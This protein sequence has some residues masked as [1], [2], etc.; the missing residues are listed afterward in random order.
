M[1]RVS[2]N[3]RALPISV[4]L[5]IVAL[6]AVFALYILTYDKDAYKE[7]VAGRRFGF[8][9]GRIFVAQ[10]SESR[11][12]LLTKMR[13]DR[14][15]GSDAGGWY[16][17]YNQD[18]FLLWQFMGVQEEKV[19]I[20]PPWGW[21]SPWRSD[22]AY[23]P[24]PTQC[25]DVRLCIVPFEFLMVVAGIPLGIK[26]VSAIRNGIRSKRWARKGLCPRCGYDVRA[27]NGIC[28]ECGY[29]LAAL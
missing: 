16:R 11:P 1:R 12:Y 2:F 4:V 23:A 21:D 14:T 9:N 6:W 28:G 20:I 10:A 8:A 27:S 26:L 7:A 5:S 19:S 24:A 29:R 25:V 15:F 3:W 22:K 13:G 18:D 17:I